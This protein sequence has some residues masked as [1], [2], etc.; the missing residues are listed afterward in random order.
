MEWIS[1]YP[2]VRTIHTYKS[3]PNPGTD[4]CLVLLICVCVCVAILRIEPRALHVLGNHSTLSHI[5]SPVSSLGLDWSSWLPV[6]QILF[7]PMYEAF[8]RDS[9]YAYD[10]VLLLF[11]TKSYSFI[12]LWHKTTSVKHCV[13]AVCYDLSLW[14]RASIPWSVRK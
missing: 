3:H 6:P 12:K 1:L 4:T 13:F 14:S 8:S 5:P 7:T 10:P 11:L 2:I 9:P